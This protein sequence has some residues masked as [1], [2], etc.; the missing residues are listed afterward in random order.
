MTHRAP[1]LDR[2]TTWL[3]DRGWVVWIGL[4][5]PVAMALV[6]AFTF[7]SEGCCSGPA[8]GEFGDFFGGTLNPLLAYF[9]LVALALTLREQR[10]M[11]ARLHQRASIDDV[12]RAIDR[13]VDALDKRLEVQWFMRPSHPQGDDIHDVG[14]MCRCIAFDTTTW[15]DGYLYGGGTRKHLANTPGL[16]RAMIRWHRLTQLFAEYLRQGGSRNV[17][18]IYAGNYAA[19]AVTFYALRPD[20]FT[21]EMFDE[22]GLRSIKERAVQLERNYASSDAREEAEKAA[23]AAAKAAGT[24]P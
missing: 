18:A 8:W 23:F 21:T 19:E 17:V 5:A 22:F 6:Y 24:P 10:R 3:F 12:Q 20:L 7:W 11:T 2:L 13:A 9:S 15:R 16:R 4:L 14:D 1:L